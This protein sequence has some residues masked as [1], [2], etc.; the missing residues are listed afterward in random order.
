MPGRDE[1]NH[2]L[3]LR[4]A[5]WSSILAASPKFCDTAQHLHVGLDN[6]FVLHRL[7]LDRGLAAKNSNTWL[8]QT[9]L[10]VGFTFN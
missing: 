2:D 8:A 6:A 4:I 1:N 3:K 9:R 5:C 10:F 7:L